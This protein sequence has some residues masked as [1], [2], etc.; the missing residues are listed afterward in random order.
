MSNL[1]GLTYAL[2]QSPSFL[3]P[4]ATSSIPEF[5]K[6][7]FDFALVIAGV[8]AVGM[9][10]VGGIF[11]S[12]SGAVDKKS[13]GKEMIMGALWG[14]LLLLASYVILRTV[15]PELVNLNLPPLE[16]VEFSQCTKENMTIKTNKGDIEPKKCDL[17]DWPFDFDTGKCKCYVDDDWK[18]EYAKFSEKVES[19]PDPSTVEIPPGTISSKGE[20][21]FKDNF[22]SNSKA[23]Q[24]KL[25][26]ITCA[27]LKISVH[28]LAK[29]AFETAC[30][31]IPSGTLLVCNKNL[32]SSGVFNWRHID[33]NPS[34]PL[35]NHS[36]GTAFDL[37]A[38]GCNFKDY[39]YRNSCKPV[40]RKKGASC[41]PVPSLQG[42][43]NVP[44]LP[45]SIISAFKTTPGFRW[46]GDYKN[47]TDNMHFEWLGPCA[48]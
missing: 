39:C 34:K 16:Q 45:S 2:A 10:V 6:G 3:A 44:N 21:C 8:L 14:L 20:Q 17:G 1:W 47:F 27:G 42:Q 26:T 11:Y 30:A 5:L 29:P 41:T 35:S 15:N 31:K 24:S 40:S 13:L 18:I 33:D 23:V 28:Q 25:V 12:I 37:S 32:F 9:I 48:S 43:C 7:F 36:F 38:Y 46:G 22:G 4:S 19:E